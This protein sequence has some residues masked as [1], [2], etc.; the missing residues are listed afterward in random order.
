[1]ADHKVGEG[2]GAIPVAFCKADGRQSG[3]RR[4]DQVQMPPRPRPTEGVPKM[5]PGLRN[6]AKA[7]FRAS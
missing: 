2:R 1:M 7:Q 4:Q 3:Q 6:L 5:L